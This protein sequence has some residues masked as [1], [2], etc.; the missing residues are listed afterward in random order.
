M[1]RYFR[2]LFRGEKGQSLAEYGAIVALLSIG[3]LSLLSLLYEQVAAIFGG[4]AEVLS[5]LMNR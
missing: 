5:T 2:R 4:T 3:V 1:R